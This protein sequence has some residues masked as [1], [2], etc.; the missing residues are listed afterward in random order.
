MMHI[1]RYIQL[2]KHHARITKHDLKFKEKSCFI[3]YSENWLIILNN[4]FKVILIKLKIFLLKDD[5]KFY[6][7]LTILPRK[8]LFNWI[9]NIKFWFNY[10]Q[11]HYFFHLINFN[12]ITFFDLIN[13]NLITLFYLIISLLSKLL[14]S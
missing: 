7:A 5:D 9:N 11:F 2:T 13:V 8:M 10:F 6:F 1:I 4:K 3:V 14:H 12:L